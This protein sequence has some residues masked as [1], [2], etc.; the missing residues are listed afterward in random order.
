[1]ETIVFITSNSYLLHWKMPLRKFQIVID[2]IPIGLDFS[3]NHI[4]YIII[5]SNRMLK[6]HKKISK[7][8][9]NACKFMGWHSSNKLQIF[10]WLD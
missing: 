1:M 8:C 3:Q 10:L 5:F 7:R 9:L 6:E 4:D 2:K